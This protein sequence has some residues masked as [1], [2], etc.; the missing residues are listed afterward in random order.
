LNLENM[1][2]LITIILCVTC[3]SVTAIAQSGVRIGNLEFVIKKT[4]HDTITQITVDEP[5]P[6]C[7]SEKE[8]RPKANPYKRPKANPYK[9][10]VSDGYCG[11]GFILPDNGKDYYTALGVSS[12]NIDL[13][14]ERRYHLSRRF[15]V[16]GISQ[17]SFY[18]YRLRPADPA[19]LWEVTGR[20]IAK[21]D[22]RKQVYRSHNIAA[23]V[24]TRFY[25]S[26]PKASSG[27]GGMYVDVGAQGDLAFSKYCKIKTHSSG[28]SKD[29][30]PYAFNPLSASAIARI[31]WG[32]NTIF[33]RY[34]LTNVFNKDVLAMD[35]PPIT[36]GM[37]FF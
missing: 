23:G 13:G 8:T 11:L 9:Q 2:K 33:V 18:N 27:K 20:D 26:P 7:P 31:G 22:I 25:L 12:F 29:R 10:K 24:F 5:C 21:N 1:K 15:A 17:Y 36:I 14:G 4:E 30:D 32:S 35:L 34:R 37:Q 19:Y 3:V 16:G 28:K 6:P